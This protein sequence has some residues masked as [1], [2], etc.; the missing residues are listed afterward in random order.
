NNTA[1][2]RQRF[3][4]QDDEKDYRFSAARSPLC[5]PSPPGSDQEM[6]VN[7]EW[8]PAGLTCDSRSAVV[9]CWN[10]TD[11]I[12]LNLKDYSFYVGDTGDDLLGKSAKGADLIRV[13]AHEVGHWLGLDH[14]DG[15]GNIM[16]DQLAAARCIDDRNMRLINA[17]AHG[18]VRRNYR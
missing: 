3:C 9:A 11:L 14:I 13:F 15:D 5:R 6:V 16:S 7:L 8:R 12:E 1:R 10:G 17:V 18:D 4:M 2:Q